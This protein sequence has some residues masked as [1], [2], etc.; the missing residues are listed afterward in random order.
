M[1]IRPPVFFRP[2][3]FHSI[4]MELLYVW[5]ELLFL[6]FISLFLSSACQKAISFLNIFE[7]HTQPQELFSS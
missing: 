5:M 1:D 7:N 2:F 6:I 3:I 4:W